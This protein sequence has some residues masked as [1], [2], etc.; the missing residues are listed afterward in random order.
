VYLVEP[1]LRFAGRQRT[2]GPRRRWHGRKAQAMADT[3]AL[4]VQAATP[5]TPNVGVE[6]ADTGA[7]D[8]DGASKRGP[9]LCV[10][11]MEGLGPR[12]LPFV[13]S[14]LTCSFVLQ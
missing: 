13:L 14:N 10:R 2:D 3:A 5:V 7:A 4:R 11:S 12:V 6:A 9:P 1:L 8:G